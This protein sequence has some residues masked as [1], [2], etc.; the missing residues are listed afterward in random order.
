[1]IEPF[2]GYPSYYDSNYKLSIPNVGACPPT[3]TTERWGIIAGNFPGPYVAPLVDNRCTTPSI[4]LT[5]LS[6]ASYNGTYGKDINNYLSDPISEGG[7]YS[8]YTLNSGLTTFYLYPSMADGAEGYKY[9]WVI[10]GEDNIYPR[11]VTEPVSL[12][13][14]SNCPP[15]NFTSWQYLS[16]EGIIYRDNITPIYDP[17]NELYAPYATATESGSARF[18]RLY[19]LGYV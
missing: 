3:S 8:S 13:A 18:R 1:M 4:T 9:N 14:L 17:V 12:S 10:T 11:Y 15:T 6:V 2:A 16:A 5:G 7:L 19:A